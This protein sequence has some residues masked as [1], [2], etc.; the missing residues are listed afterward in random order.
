MSRGENE[1]SSCAAPLIRER[2][3]FTNAGCTAA[4]GDVSLRY[5]VNAVFANARLFHGK[6]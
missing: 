3:P 2:S 4:S 1:A 5:W 6:C